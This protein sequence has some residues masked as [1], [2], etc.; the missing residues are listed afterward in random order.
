ML[1]RAAFLL[2]WQ[3]ENRS[4]IADMFAGSIGIRFCAPRTESPYVSRYETAELK[5]ESSFGV[6]AF[7]GLWYQLNPA[8]N[9]RAFGVPGFGILWD[10][11][12]PAD[13]DS[14]ARKNNFEL[15][16]RTATVAEWFALC[17]MAKVMAENVVKLSSEKGDKKIENPSRREIFRL[18]ALL[19]TPTKKVSM[20][21][22]GKPHPE[23][24]F[25]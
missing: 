5:D 7:S 15:K 23:T 25:S 14:G 19:K 6:G 1:V 12:I 9:I 8:S 4:F 24:D 3:L 11:P 21:W 2:E 22:V 20:I 13:V 18:E 10:A 17:P 16:H